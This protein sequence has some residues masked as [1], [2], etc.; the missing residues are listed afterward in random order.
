MPQR[1][2]I[3]YRESRGIPSWCSNRTGGTSFPRDMVALKL[4]KVPRAVRVPAREKLGSPELRKGPP[5]LHRAITSRR[6]VAPKVREH[7]SRGD[8][9]HG[10]DQHSSCVPYSMV[11]L[12]NCFI[13]GQL[14]TIQPKLL[15][16]FTSKRSSASG[17]LHAAA[18][19][20]ACFQ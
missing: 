1:A 15:S 20:R 12:R 11:G 5:P 10:P 17:H 13:P 18:K 8:S 19:P 6:D 9:V 14:S 4:N 7:Q 3:Q 16:F 2:N